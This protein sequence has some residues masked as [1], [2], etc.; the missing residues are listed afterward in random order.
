M[1]SKEMNEY[2]KNI[3]PNRP[4]KLDQ[5]I[6][7]KPKPTRRQHKATI[8]IQSSKH[9]LKQPYS[10]QKGIW[11][12]TLSGS[13]QGDKRNDEKNIASLIRKF[14]IFRGQKQEE[15]SFFALR[16]TLLLF[17]CYQNAMGTLSSFQV[18]ETNDGKQFLPSNLSGLLLS[19]YSLQC[20]KVRQAT[21]FQE[22]KLKNQL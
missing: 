6:S 10:K 18:Q 9:Q 22:E 21:F 4:I 8:N 5:C 3:S 1:F 16:L 11:M 14:L 15:T 12:K 19:F 7:Y 17:N 20:S 13:R 2:K